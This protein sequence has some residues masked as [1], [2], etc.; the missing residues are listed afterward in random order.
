MC[1]GDSEHQRRVQQQRLNW[2]A[3]RPANINSLQQYEACQQSEDQL[4]Q[5]ESLVQLMNERMVVALSR[6]WCCGSGV[7]RVHGGDTC[8]TAGSSRSVACHMLGASFW[9]SVPTVTC[10]ACGTTWELSPAAAGCWGSSP[11]VPNTWF[12]KQLLE[13]YR[14]LVLPG[15]LSTAH[16]QVPAMLLLWS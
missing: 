16:L 3:R 2:D 10:D 12:D 11:V 8:I 7:I 13:F 6:H 14:H 1:H 9:L 15:G 5:R 4:K